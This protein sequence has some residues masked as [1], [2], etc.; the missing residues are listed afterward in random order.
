ESRSGGSP[1]LSL[2]ETFL[3]LA[4]KDPRG[5]TLL[6][7]AIDRTSNEKAK[8][9]LQDRLTR[10]FPDS[11]SVIALRGPR[12]PSEWVGKP[13]DL[14]FTDAVSGSLVSMK[15]LKGKVV[16]IDFW[17]TWCGPCVAEMPKMKQ[18]YANYRN[19]GVEFIGVSLDEP[20][21]QGGLEKLTS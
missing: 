20:L 7:V 21:D 8:A 18:L 12:N 5:A 15:Q 13:F 16:V 3:K 19:R 11:P 10:S 2:L 9:A 14:E 1:D 17:A 6:E 4:P